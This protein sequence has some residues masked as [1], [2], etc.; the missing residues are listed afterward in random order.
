MDLFLF[1]AKTIC[2]AQSA[3]AG[4]GSPAGPPDDPEFNAFDRVFVRVYPQHRRRS[5]ELPDIIWTPGTMYHVISGAF[6]QVLASH[7]LGDDVGFIPTTI[8]SDQG[9]LWCD[10]YWLLYS[11]REHEIADYDRSEVIWCE[12]IPVTVR[13]WVVNSEKVPASDLFYASPN[14]WFAT[15]ELRLA[16][17]RNSISGAKLMRVDVV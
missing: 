4:D 2:M 8:Q 7:C 12:D 14:D 3:I 11:L 6:K 13:K 10:D 15:D 1:S 16:M 17:Q 5:T 9:E